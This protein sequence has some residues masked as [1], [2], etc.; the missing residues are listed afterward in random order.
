LIFS[1]QFSY[2][3]ILVAIVCTVALFLFPAAHG[4]YAAVHGPVTTLRSIKT[5]I[6]I[7]ILMA[8]AAARLGGWLLSGYGSALHILRQTVLL[9]LSS[10]FDRAS[11]LRC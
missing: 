6:R 2:E 7:W 1:R 4:S 11:V 8:V 5:K 9:F 10:P 3:F